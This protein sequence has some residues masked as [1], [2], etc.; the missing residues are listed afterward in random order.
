MALYAT[1]VT[2]NF[3]FFFFLQI[4]EET[5][6]VFIEVTSSKTLAKAKEVLDTLLLTIMQNNL[7]PERN[8]ADK[9]V[10]TVQQVR[11]EDE[12]GKLR[13]LYPSRTDLIYENVRIRVV[14]P[15]K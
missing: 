5:T 9:T 4:T 7:C 8:E 10:M 11:V 15:E 13:V 2:D 14:M 3:F 1:G 6:D 12:D